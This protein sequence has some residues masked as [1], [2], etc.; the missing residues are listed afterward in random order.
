MKNRVLKFRCWNTIIERMSE[1]ILINKFPKNTQWQ[2]LNVMQFTGF[3]DKNGVEIYEGDVI[4]D[5]TDVDG[6]KTQSK[7]QVFWD[8][9]TGS[10]HLDHSFY[11]NKTSSYN[12]C[13]ELQDFKYEVI[14][15][16][17]ENI[18]LVNN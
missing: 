2:N 16:I 4:G 3:K 17:Y 9:P 18:E 6:K 14:G 13:N 8:E 15:N 5:W 7:M 10:W 12:L 11:Q 1:N